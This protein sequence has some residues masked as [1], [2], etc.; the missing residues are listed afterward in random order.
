VLGPVCVGCGAIQPPPAKPDLF[1]VLALPK[2]W[3]LDSVE[4]DR[5]WREVSRKVHPDRF[6]GKSAVERRMSL[7]WTAIVNEARRVLRD[8]LSRARYLAS[9]LT[10]PPEEGG[11]VLDPDFLEEMFDLRMAADDD[12]T[13]VLPRA[14][15]WRGEILGELEGIFSR[16]ATGGGDLRDVEE[17]LARLKYLDNLVN[18][19]RA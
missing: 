11:P 10:H 16:W 5:A 4:L 15:S 9:G 19:A 18:S 6:A 3:K 1:G 13:A 8:P 12:P 2:A 17:R 14:E 7:Q